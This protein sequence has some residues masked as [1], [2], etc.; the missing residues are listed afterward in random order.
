MTVYWPSIGTAHKHGARM[1]H[2]MSSGPPGW[3][4][5]EA[6]QAAFAQAL[7]EVD[8]VSFDVFDTA[9][10]RLTDTPRDIFAAAERDLVLQW[11]DMA[12]GF[13]A[14]RAQSEWAARQNAAAQQREEVGLDEIYAELARHMPQLAPLLAQIQQAEL[15]AETEFCKPVPDILRAH[16]HALAANKRVLFLSDMYLPANFVRGLLRGCGFGAAPPLWI[17]SETGRTKSRGG[18]WPL[19]RREIGPPARL[20]HIGD[21]EHADRL[22]PAAH[23]VR[24]LP[25]I[26]A[27][28]SRRAGAVA[29]PAILP[30][31]RAQRTAE[32]AARHP[33]TPETNE[34]A[35]HR[36]GQVLGG[37][38]VGGF[39]RWLEPRLLRY[40]IDHVYFCARDGWL[41]HQ[42]WQAADI[43]ARTGI[44]A[45]YLYVSRWPLHLARAHAEASGTRLTP[46]L[47][48][49][50]IPETPEMSASTLLRQARLDQE[51]DITQ[52]AYSALGALDVPLA[53]ADRL[54][55]LRNILAAH[56][57]PVLALAAQTHAALSAYLAQ[58]GFGTT[59][60]PAIIDLGWHGTM[61]A[62][63]S[64]ILRAGGRN[65]PLAGFYY[66]LWPAASG[67]RPAA[68]WME[69]AFGNDFMAPSELQPLR[70]TADMLEELHGAPEGSVRDYRC[71]N[72]R[73][74]P[75]LADAQAERQAYQSITRP[76]QE[77]TLAAISA[78]FSKGQ[79]G[80][81]RLADLTP[82]A[83]LA[84]LRAVLLA[85]TSREVA[86][87]GGLVHCRGTG[88]DTALPVVGPAPVS[89]PAHRL[90]EDLAQRSWPAGVLR[91]WRDAVDGPDRATILA[92]A[93]DMFPFLPEHELRH[94]A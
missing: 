31:S 11:G 55:S 76:F 33:A 53:T 28:S 25:F 79:H 94:Y 21:D 39:L 19:L 67:Q 59:A 45:S 51:A 57:A 36:T 82:E 30:F 68:G 34:A 73:W 48:H 91:A 46:A 63:L 89:A 86:L 5:D 12:Q 93:R 24:V 64:Q 38:M 62:A 84:A 74:M 35:R 58:E 92:L 72:G 50:L 44:A 1:E 26:R 15:A 41:L 75:V 9:I 23:G 14:A 87:F 2:G 77:G 18:I 65:V 32:L 16:A 52:A 54:A 49:F 69:A 10:T 8:I 6:W 90:Q 66:A 70:R 37:L 20:L 22:Q 88:H 60:R 78:L 40:G 3:R 61:Q 27:R 17:S 42:A 85:P 80:S 43:S 13:A 7:D 56:P 83:G 47:L 29:M 81:L 4:V 71:D